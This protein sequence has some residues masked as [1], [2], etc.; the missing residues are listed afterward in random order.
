[1]RDLNRL[2]GAVF[3]IDVPREKIA[4]AECKRLG[5]PLIAMC[6]TNCDPDG[7]TYPIPSN[8]DAIRAITLVTNAVAE[9]ATSGALEQE[10]SAADEAMAAAVAGDGDEAE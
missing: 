10:T 5:I 2:P 7:I 1:L 3:V 9:A 4:V 6:D 8:D